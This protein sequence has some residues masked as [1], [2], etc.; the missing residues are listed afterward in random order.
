M[1][2]TCIVKGCDNKEKVYS[3]VMFHRIPT[4]H[5]QWR[6]WLAALNKNPKTPLMTLKKWRVCSEHFTP[7]DYTCT[8]TRL[9]DEATPTIFKSLTQQSGSSP[10]ADKTMDFARDNFKNIL[11]TKVSGLKEVSSPE[12]CQVILLFCPIVSRAGTDIDAALSNL[13]HVK[14]KYFII[15]TGKSCNLRNQI[16]H[17]LLRQIP[18][19]KEVH[20]VKD[21]DVILVFCTIFSRAGTDIDAALNELNY[22]SASKPAIFMVLH[23]TFEPEKIIPDSSRYVT[24][25]KTLTVD[26]LFNEDEELKMEQ[27]TDNG[28]LHIDDQ[29]HTDVN[30]TEEHGDERPVITGKRKFILLPGKTSKAQEDTIRNV[31]QQ[32]PD[33]EEVSTVEE[34]DFILVFCIIVSR[35]GTDID[36]AVNELNALSETKPAVFMVLHHTFDTEK[37]VPDSSSHVTRMNTLTVDCLFYEGE[38]LHCVR[39]H[40]AL[41]RIKQCFPPQV[42]HNLQLLLLSPD[43]N[44]T[45]G[46]CGV[47]KVTGAR[48][49]TSLT[50]NVMAVIDKPEGQSSQLETDNGWLHTDDQPHADV[51]MTEEHGDERPVITGNKYFI[52]LPGKTSKAQEDTIR[53]VLQQT[54]DLEEVFTVEECDFILVFC[55]IVSRPR[56]DIDAA[57][58]ELNALSETKPAV[59]M[60]LHHTFDPEKMVP[61]S[62]SHVTRMNT[63]TVDCLFY[64]GEF[65]HCVRNHEALDRIKQCFPPQDSGLPW[66][67]R[68]SQIFRVNVETQLDKARQF[69]QSIQGGTPQTSPRKRKFI[70]LPG[71]TSKAQE[72]TIRNVLQQTPD[73]E[74]VS[75]VEECDFILVFCII[76]SRAGTDIDAAVNELNALSE[77][78]PAVFMVLHHT[79]DP[80]KMV[81]D[82]SSHVTRMNTLT[83]DCLFYEGEFLDC[84]R[85]HEALDRIKQCFPPQVSSSSG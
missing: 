8:G 84:V 78:K 4:H 75:T 23:H 31:L 74:E 77:T 67:R 27:E 50:R 6:A 54:P 19:L 76:V 41:D 24:R 29:Q 25:M 11:H 38:F 18:N 45:C 52:L 55:I 22:C 32:T 20:S 49:H 71:K 57:V 1:V 17:N 68:L 60:V 2:I 28:W 40:E 61:D 53:N 79:F 39:N 85:N 34:C 80:E 73:L 36:A 48:S 69:F 81:P 10:N 21:C 46:A 37:M 14:G 43:K 44:I 51:N 9:K 62:S 58:N 72:D 63:L 66:F 3:A 65:L 16:L 35:A 13:N 64:E 15:E 83:V 5:I 82:S 47:W 26:C 42:T 12:Q 59:F 33:P 56:P 70:L 7:E 30:M